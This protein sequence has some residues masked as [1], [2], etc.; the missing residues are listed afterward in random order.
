MSR[1]EKDFLAFH[2]VFAL[3]CVAVLAAPLAVQ[4]GPRMAALTALYLVAF[5]FT[6]I[7]RGHRWWVDLWAFAFVTSAFQVFPDWFLSAELGILVFPPDGF[8]KIGTVSGYMAGLWSIPL[9]CVIFAGRRAAERV[10]TRAGYVAA[11]IASLLVFGMS[12]ETVWM[13]PSWYATGVRTLGHTALYVIVPEILLGL[14]A[15][16]MYDRVRGKGLRVKLPA[17]FCVMAFYLGNLAL[18]FFLVERILR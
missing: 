15:Y 10:S 4:A 16:W 1:E 9:V 14:S 3:L 11:A 2:L 5:P 12:E 17:A 7:R 6:A 18:F 13:I 8:P